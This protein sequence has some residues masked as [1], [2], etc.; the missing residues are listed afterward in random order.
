M[1]LD[2]YRVNFGQTILKSFRE[3]GWRLYPVDEDKRDETARYNETIRQGPTS[4]IVLDVPYLL[5]PIT[6]NPMD[7]KSVKLAMQ[8]FRNRTEQSVPV[9]ELVGDD[10]SIKGAYFRKRAAQIFGTSG[11]YVA[12]TEFMDSI[13]TITPAFD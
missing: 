8:I 12:Y 10:H 9:I 1:L 5:L 11:V 2:D 3:K 13:Y 6:D 4:R 7:P